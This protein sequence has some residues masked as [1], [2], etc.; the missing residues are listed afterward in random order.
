MSIQSNDKYG[1]EL[2]YKLACE[3]LASTADIEGQC[4]RSGAQCWQTD[5]GRAVLVEYLKRPYII[6]L[7]DVEVSLFDSAEPAALKDKLLILH[8]FTLAKGTP[9]ANKWIAYQELSGG[10][11]YYPTFTKRAIT[12][13]VKYFG[14]EP[15]RL[16]AVAAELGGYKADC[17]DVAVTINA[18][19]RVPVTLVLWR[20]DDE[21]SPQ[22]NILFDSTVAD[23]LTTEDINVL[24]ETIVWRLVRLVK[25]GGDNADRN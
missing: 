25:A 12:P 8:Y 4:L 14:S 7:P 24:C 1:S 18:F 10:L 2:A 9:L 21:F 13:L 16:V 3:Q 11:N 23:Y 6:S 5:Y 22:G 19:S 20:G 17:G 15:Q